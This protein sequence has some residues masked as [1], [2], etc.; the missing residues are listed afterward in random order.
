MSDKVSAKRN[1]ETD[2]DTYQI[3]VVAGPLAGSTLLV[4]VIPGDIVE[5]RMT[6]W[7]RLNA[8]PIYYDHNE[9]VQPAGY[10]PS[11]YQGE[12]LISVGDLLNAGDTIT[13]MVGRSL[14][15]ILDVGVVTD[16]AVIIKRRRVF[17]PER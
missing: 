11:A 12:H 14:Y 5:V 16:V 17:V 10:S 3:N 9:S 6:N 4:E 13:V 15:A 1:G 7:D 8:K 2:W